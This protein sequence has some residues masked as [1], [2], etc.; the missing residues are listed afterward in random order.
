MVRYRELPACGFRRKWAS[1]PRRAA[2]TCPGPDG[3]VV[4]GGRSAANPSAR[5][6]ARRATSVRRCLRAPLR[7]A[8][9][10]AAVACGCGLTECYRFPCGSFEPPMAA[11]GRAGTSSE[12]AWRARCAAE[13][14]IHLG[15]HLPGLSPCACDGCLMCCHRIH[16]ASCSSISPPPGKQR[17]SPRS[18]R[19]AACDERHARA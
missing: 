7:A 3:V 9:I 15:P 10:L 16:T 6:G 18:S 14:P 19:A 1:G 2:R 4:R 5:R 11:L 13:Q 17:I 8:G 12:A